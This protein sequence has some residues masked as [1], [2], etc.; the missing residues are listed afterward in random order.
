MHLRIGEV[1]MTM[2]IN[3]GRENRRGSRIETYGM[4]FRCFEFMTN[5]S[6]AAHTKEI[7]ERIT[8]KDNNPNHQHK[9]LI[10]S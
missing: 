4:F 1:Q 6:R 2:F 5:D 3:W 10:T 8:S 7:V 9:A